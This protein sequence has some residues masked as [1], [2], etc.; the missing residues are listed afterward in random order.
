MPSMQARKY[1]STE[2]HQAREHTSIRACEA[3]DLAD[4]CLAESSIVLESCCTFRF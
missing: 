3:Y 1:A 4:S 2:A